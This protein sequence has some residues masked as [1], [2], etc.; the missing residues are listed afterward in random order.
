[1]PFISGV[2]GS[3]GYAGIGIY[4]PDPEPEYKG[5]TMFFAQAFAP[6]GWQQIDL[7][8]MTLRVTTGA[9]LSD[10]GSNPFSSTYPS[11]VF[12]FP[13]STGE[14]LF[15]SGTNFTTVAQ[16]PSHLHYGNN[17]AFV[18]TDTTHTSGPTL[19][20]RMP[21]VQ[22]P[23]GAYTGY[24]GQAPGPYT[25]TVLPYESPLYSP[26]NLNAPGGGHSHG[27]FPGGIRITSSSTI[28]LRIKY[29]YSIL[30][31]KK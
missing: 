17:S 7:N 24:P 9:I 26:T 19:G 30:A 31:T 11:T 27:Q 5:T 8:D 22:I 3:K 20:S 29:I 14:W 4:T 10:G 18:N 6:T 13:S 23:G 12:N 1:M 28:D 15:E 16:M 21:S 2:T 25:K